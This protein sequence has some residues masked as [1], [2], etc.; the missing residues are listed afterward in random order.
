MELGCVVHSITLGVALGV[1][2]DSPRLVLT[3]MAV[4]AVHQAIEGLALGAV[5]AATDGL[6]FIRKAVLAL[7][8][9]LTLPLGIVAGIAASGG[10]DA[11]SVAARSVQGVANGVSGGMLLHVSLFSLLGAEFTQHDLLHRPGLAAVMMLAAL[12]G[13]GGMCVLGIWA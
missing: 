9:A 11:A 2:T 10:Y 4:L 3:L 12:L 6:T 13:I 5:L 8:Y 7:C 1:M